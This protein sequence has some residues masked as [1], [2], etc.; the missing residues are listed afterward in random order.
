MHRRLVLVCNS[1][2]MFALLIAVIAYHNAVT[3]ADWERCH[4]VR[5]A[6]WTISLDSRSHHVGE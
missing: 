4:S 5:T 3:S 1:S 6:V 2:V